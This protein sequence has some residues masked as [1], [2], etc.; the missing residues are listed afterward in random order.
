MAA[1]AIGFALAM[2]CMVLAFATPAPAEPRDPRLDQALSAFDAGNT[3]KADALL[4]KADHAAKDPTARWDA[5]ETR[6]TF[7][8]LGEDDAGAVAQLEPLISSGSALF[9]A[10]SPRLIPALRMLGAS[11]ANLGRDADSSRIALQAA[12]LGRAAGG[13]DLLSTLSDLAR[14]RVDA[15]DNAAAALLAAE[16][17]VQDTADDATLGPHAQEGAALRALALLRAG[18]PD[19]GLA[20]LMPLLRLPSGDLQDDVPDLVALFDSEAAVTDDAAMTAWTD[21]ALAIEAARDQADQTL[22]QALFPLNDALHAG[23]AVAAD[24]AGRLAFSEVALDDPLVTNGYYALLLATTKADDADLAATWALRLGAMPP[25]YLAS[26]QNDPLP[27]LETSADWLLN[28]GRVNEAVTLSEAIA[29]LAPLRD[30]PDALVVPR[31][32]ARL[33]AAY[34]DA[35][36]QPQA[37]TTLQQAL[38]NLGPAPHGAAAA[39]AVQIQTDLAYLSQDKGNIGEAEASYKA[40]RDLLATSDAGQ[41]PKAWA[42][43]L[44]AQRD[45]LITQGRLKEALAVAA[46]AVSQI[47]DHS[48]DH[49][50]APALQLAALRDLAESQLDTGDADG[51]EATLASAL[52]KMQSLTPTDALRPRLLALQAAVL[53]RLGRSDAVA[54]LQTALTPLDKG[55]MSGLVAV[56]EAAKAAQSLGDTAT[57]RQLLTTALASLPAEHPVAAYLLAG[58]AGVEAASDPQAALDDLRQATLALTQ[59]DRRSE[60]QARDHLALHVTL[61]LQMAAQTTGDAAQAL[62]T[63]AF[64]VAQ[65]V[66]DMSAGAA[67]SKATARLRGDGP[68]AAA[69]AQQLQDADRALDAARQALITRLSTGVEA[70][71]ELR[72]LDQARLYR[73]SLIANL[74]S[75]FPDYAAFADPKPV[76]LTA[77]AALLRPGEVLLLYASADPQAAVGPAHGTV[78]AVSSDAYMTADLPPRAELAALARDLRCAAALTDPGCGAG[79]SGTRGAFSFDAPTSDGPPFDLD[80]ARRAYLTLL[81]PVA[82]MLQGKTALIVVPDRSLASLPFHLLLTADTAPDTPLNRAPWLIRT[83]SVTIVPSVANLAALRGKAQTDSTS[84]LP[85]LGIGDPLIGAEAGGAQPFDC[86][87]P[88]T[89]PD[90]L[91]MTLTPASVILRGATA[92]RTALASLPAL[93]D[94]SCELRRAAALFGTPDA[95]LLQ[96]DATETRVKQLSQSG[97]LARYRV[98]SFATHGLIAGELGAANAGLVLTPPAHSSSTDDGLLT[99]AE[100]VALRLDADF[101]ILS[102]CNSAAGSA[103]QQE[104]L[105]GLASAFFLAGARSLLVSH[106]PV[107]SDAATRLTSGLIAAMAHDPGVGRA[108]ALRRSMLA[109]LDDPNADARSLHP[110]YWAPFLIAGE[111]G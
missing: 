36:R 18:H 85:F 105:S 104:G 38:T 26:L 81:E 87:S 52:P 64:Q 40:A 16:L 27:V 39:L 30:G 45:F 15:G 74:A 21:R 62:T 76:G 61:A 41:D 83:A 77:V 65:R 82:P 13:E 109:I 84:T 100:I 46:E 86:G 102:A 28:Q 106:W 17:V 33:G 50:P 67:L 97:D 12:R 68:Q 3:A 44:G 34:R 31:A 58:R 103:D 101:V 110:A 10:D 98:I 14:D 5:A 6:A 73:E 94:T 71:A 35:G 23:D 43:V 32:L 99:T 59:P 1:R 4:Q 108:E 88:Q 2:I 75:A 80:L 107:Y 60:P 70:G 8:H 53:A 25:Y 37:R 47:T 66:N 9:G 56:I 7:A 72:T 19:D 11:L 111:G 92:D 48:P 95:V 42:F 51:A 29:A 49:Q 20:R 57:A 89:P 69:L 54:T 63:E 91:A 22:L 24:A 55:D 78:F 90:L 96:G 93:P 79:R